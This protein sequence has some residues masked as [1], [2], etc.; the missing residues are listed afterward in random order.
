MKYLKYGLWLILIIVI[1]FPFLVL[2][3]VIKINKFV[4]FS[5]YD[6]CEEGLSQRISDLTGKTYFEVK[7]EISKILKDDSQIKDYSI[8]F[9]LPAT[10]KI[11]LLLT[12]PRF[13]MKNKTSEKLVLVDKNGW[14]LKEEKNTNLP[15]LIVNSELS[16]VGQKIEGVS[17]Y[18]LDVLWHLFYFYQIKEAELTNDDVEAVFPDGVKVIFPIEGDLD[19]TFAGL[20]LVFSRLNETGVDSKIGKVREI[21]LRYK[22]PIIR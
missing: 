8:Q 20:K 4:C 6:Q 18:A 14:V 13:A 16:N 21:D 9:L 10:L 15:V 12:K 11:D 22:N 19:L 17:F 7:K 1:T 3:R 5:Q 2:P